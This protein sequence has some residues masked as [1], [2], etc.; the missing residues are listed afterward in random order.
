ML[1]LAPTDN[2]AVPHG[3]WGNGWE[4]AVGREAGAGR[5]AGCALTAASSSA[6]EEPTS[7]LLAWKHRYFSGLETGSQQRLKEKKKGTG[8]VKGEI[9]LSREALVKV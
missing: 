8:G 2:T 5:S 9:F 7:G 6:P 3:L 1:R 4:E